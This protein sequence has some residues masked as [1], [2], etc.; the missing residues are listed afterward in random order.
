LEYY[1]PFYLLYMPT[2]LLDNQNKLA[3]YFIGL[4]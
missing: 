3:F 1:A 4:F 2:F